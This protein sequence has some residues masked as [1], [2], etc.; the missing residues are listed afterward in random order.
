MKLIPSDVQV[1]PA[2]STV[3]V[4]LD[5]RG[6]MVEFSVEDEGPGVPVAMREMIFQPWVKLNGDANS[7]GLGLGLTICRTAMEEL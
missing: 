4:S 6:D 1:S 5:T 3:T 7:A 2:K